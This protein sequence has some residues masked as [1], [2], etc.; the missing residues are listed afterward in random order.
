MTNTTGYTDNTVDLETPPEGMTNNGTLTVAVKT[1][2]GHTLTH[3]YGFTVEEE[4]GKV[5]A[6]DMLQHEDLGTTLLFGNQVFALRFWDI[7]DLQK[8]LDMLTSAVE[9]ELKRRKGSSD[10]E[11]I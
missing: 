8:G 9:V 10:V 2:R 4:N 11:S 6:F 1:E 3:E 5:L 7:E